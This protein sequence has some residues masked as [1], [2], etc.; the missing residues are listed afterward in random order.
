M[1]GL[2][3]DLSEANP[4]FQIAFVSLDKDPAK[5]VTWFGEN[6]GTS[7]FKDRLY[8]DPEF[9]AAEILGIDSFPMTLVVNAKG[10][11]IKVQ[12]GFE[13][14]KGLTESLRERID[15]ELKVLK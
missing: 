15:A 8:K 10:Q 14:S 13:K 12:R 1:E 6:L 5:A 2:F 11:V 3:K 7:S 9:K 4:R